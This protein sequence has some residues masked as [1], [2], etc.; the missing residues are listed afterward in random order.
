[1][2]F[3]ETNDVDE[4]VCNH[5]YK[6]AFENLDLCFHTIFSKDVLRKGNKLRLVGRSTFCWLEV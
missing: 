6:S 1:M 4:Y 2:G 3:F 5:V